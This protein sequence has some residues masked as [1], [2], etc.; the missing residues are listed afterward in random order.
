MLYEVMSLESFNDTTGLLYLNNG[1]I[2]KRVDCSQLRGRLMRASL[3][4]TE[5]D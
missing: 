3:N 5:L 1:K 2:I 4:W